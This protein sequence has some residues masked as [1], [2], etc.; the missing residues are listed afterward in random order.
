MTD[1]LTSRALFVANLLNSRSSP[2]T[3]PADRLLARLPLSEEDFTYA[4]IVRSLFAEPPLIGHRAV[5]RNGDGDLSPACGAFPA[6]RGTSVPPAFVA[7]YGRACRRC[8]WPDDVL[9]RVRHKP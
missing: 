3:E 9:S 4:V 7:P 2:G 1:K 8:T 6:G 5:W